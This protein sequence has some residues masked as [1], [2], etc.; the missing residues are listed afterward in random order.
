[1][2]LGRGSRPFTILAVALALACREDS[3]ARNRLG[4]TIHPRAV[5][6]VLGETPHRLAVVYW[7]SI[8]GCESCDA[9]I[10]DT[11]YRWVGDAPTKSAL[12]VVTVVPAGHK[13]RD[14]TYPG[15]VLAIDATT[16]VRFSDLAPHPRIEIWSS[17]G[18]LLLLR[19]VPNLSTQ[20][21]L[22]D[23]E[24]FAARV[25]TAPLPADAEATIR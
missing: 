25:F 16:Y 1:M 20:V 23:E 14:L 9:K 4:A 2:S 22:L 3:G 19:S 8:Q 13:S 18:E 10:V 12:L 24:M 15:R 21:A 11:L 7:P 6:D 5:E 17:A